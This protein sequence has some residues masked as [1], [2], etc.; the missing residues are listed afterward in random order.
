[1]IKKFSVDIVSFK[2][3]SE[4]Q[5]SRTTENYKSLLALMG[6]DEDLDAMT[7]SELKEMYLMSLN[8]FEPDDAAKFVLTFL[9]T[10]QLTPGKIEQLSHEMPED[11]MWE[12]YADHAMHK[13]LFNAYGLLREAFNGV[14]DRPT[15]VQFTV[16]IRAKDSSAFSV[17]KESPHTALV[18]L[19]SCGLD[20]SE[21]INRLYDE[22]I[23]GNTF[24]EAEGILWDLKEISHTDHELQYPVTSSE[25]WFKGLAKVTQFEA[26]AHADI[27]EEVEID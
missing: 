14:F 12:E 26:K 9:F 20:E 10:E 7:P 6:L 16:N 27:L 21:V 2:K 23:A 3:I 17:F 4:I 1:M 5:N 13:Q 19:L 15:G 22:Q 18:R 11:R 25:F 24:A 8:D